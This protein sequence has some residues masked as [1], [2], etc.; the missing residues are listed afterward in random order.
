MLLYLV[1]HAV[2]LQHDP[3][4]WPDD[5]GRPL[6]PEG[7][8]RFR[9]AARGLAR[10]ASAPEVVLS[11]QFVRAWRT[12][13][14]LAEESG[15][16]GPTA[17]PALGAEAPVEEAVEAV[18]GLLDQPD[19]LAAAMVGHEPNLSLVAAH[20]LTEGR[21]DVAIEMRK[22]AVVCLGL[23]RDGQAVLWWS[24]SPKIL[25]ALASPAR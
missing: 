23:E 17:E 7:E 24:L 14:L 6:S 13:E 8:A 20:L 16:P 15:W 12:A 25:R 3:D 21:N 1:R 19:R 4:R 10:I 9:T 22:G 5:T 2:A 18:R 11:S